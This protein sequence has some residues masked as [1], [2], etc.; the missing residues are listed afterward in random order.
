L[1]WCKS[2]QVFVEEG[3]KKGVTK[4]VSVNKIPR[5]VKVN[6]GGVEDPF[7]LTGFGLHEP[8][9]TRYLRRATRRA[10]GI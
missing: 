6:E 10:E 5:V 3:I 7:A 1:K 8:V 2:H 4:S 9:E